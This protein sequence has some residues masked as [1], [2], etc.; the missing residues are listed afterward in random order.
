MRILRIVVRR[1][2]AAIPVLLFLTAVVFLLTKASGV[3]PARASLGANARPEAVERVREELW[4]DRPLPLQYLHYNERLLR[5]DLGESLRTHRPVTEDLRD[6]LPSTAELALVATMLAVLLGLVIGMSSAMAWR[7]SSFVRLF[8]IAGASVPVFLVAIGGI[9]LFYGKLGWL[10]ATGRSSYVDAPSGPTGFLLVDS[11]LAGRPPVF[12][13]AVW[14]MIMPA[15]ALA[16]GPAVAIGRVLRNSLSENLGADYVRTA[17][18]KGLG[19]WSILR[20]HALRN[21]LNAPLSMLGLQLGLIFAA[22]VV[23]E[24]IFAWPGIGTYVT[25]AIPTNDFP[26]IA[27]VTL[28]VGVAYIMLNMLVDILQAVADPRISLDAAPAGWRRVPGTMRRMTGA[29]GGGGG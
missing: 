24:L 22:D 27:A 17:R 15:F 13:D 6:A 4:L 16:L 18:S 23:V 2:L 8:M 12:F 1:L 5:G 7:G 14:H 28:M 25:E 20:K 11:L 9:W 21:A 29:A 26:V 19:E 3:D 10:P